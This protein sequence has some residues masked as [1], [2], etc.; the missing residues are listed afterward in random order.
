MHYDAIRKDET[1]QYTELKQWHA[2]N[3]CE[4][5]D[6]AMQAKIAGRDIR[7]DGEYREAKAEMK[8][9]NKELAKIRAGLVRGVD[10]VYGSMSDT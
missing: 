5:H 7:K 1:G 6:R 3:F 8:G 10:S 9:S 4:W 2:D